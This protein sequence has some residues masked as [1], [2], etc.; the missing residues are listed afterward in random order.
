MTTATEFGGAT[1][2]INDLERY[3]NFSVAM[4][5]FAYE[6][7][8]L[9]GRQEF[10]NDLNAEIEKQLEKAAGA[11]EIYQKAAADQIE[12]FERFAQLRV[13]LNP[14]CGGFAILAIVPE[15]QVVQLKS[16]RRLSRDVERF[17]WSQRE[18]DVSIW[19]MA[20]DHPDQDRIAHDFPLFQA[21]EDG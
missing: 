8:V 17:M 11:A 10:F 6:V 4:E 20:T 7:G 15:A 21:P 1:Q 14:S 18:L 12:G 3:C 2:Q 9:Q 13:G 16:L 5:R 19:T